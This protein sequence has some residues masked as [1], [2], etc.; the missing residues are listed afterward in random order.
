MKIKSYT[1]AC[2]FSIAVLGSCKT[3]ETQNT[4]PQGIEVLTASDSTALTTLVRNVYEWHLTQHQKNG[5]PFKITGAKKNLI[6]GIDWDAYENEI[7]KLRK[8][9]YFSDYFFAAHQTI[10]RSIDSSIQQTDKK[11]RNANDG[12]SIW[13]TGA[14]DWCDFQDYPDDYWKFL[15]LNNFK[16]EK[17]MVTFY[18]SWG[19]N[20]E[21]QYQMKATKE[22]GKWK[23]SHMQGFNSYSTVAGYKKIIQDIEKGEKSS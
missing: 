21:K 9:Q 18:W 6:A 16:F 14:D 5:F 12:M 20:N 23:I 17:G 7:Q 11:W 3:P 1:I 19:D 15:T 10:A 2:I 22:E 8:T 4:N 13:E